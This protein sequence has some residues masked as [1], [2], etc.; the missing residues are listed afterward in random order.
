MDE[1]PISFGTLILCDLPRTLKVDE[2]WMR[3][4][5]ILLEV[6]KRITSGGSVIQ[7]YIGVLKSTTL[8]A[9]FSPF[10]SAFQQTS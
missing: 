1:K 2:K 4:N 6:K 8:V 5:G 9:L 7:N 3:D 10:Y